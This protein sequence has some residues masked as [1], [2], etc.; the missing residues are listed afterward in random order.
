MTDDQRRTAIYHGSIFV[1]SPSENAL[2]LC[3]LAK[4]LIEDAFASFD[5]LGV[6]ENISAEKCAEILAALKSKF[7]H[8]PQSKEFI[9]GILEEAG[10][11]LDQTHFDVPRMR[12]A[13]PGDYLKSG[14]A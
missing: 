8:H 11:D 1:H 4:E 14:I 12:T 9:Q 5:P 7:I 10:C 13:F 3:R 2:K 6:H